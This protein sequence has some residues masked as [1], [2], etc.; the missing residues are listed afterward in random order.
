M[1]QNI[2][3]KSDKKFQKRKPGVSGRKRRNI[4]VGV[5]NISSSFNNVI[6]SIT[7]TQ[8]NVIAWSSAGKSGFKGSRKSTPYAAQVAVSNAVEKAKEFGLQT[9]TV[10]VRGAGVGREPALRVLQSSGISIISVTDNTYYPHNGCR[11]PKR[12]R[13]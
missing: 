11:P 1:V 12:R 7:D 5:I 13:M 4:V 10:I 2:A 6:I 3:E 8:G 9:A